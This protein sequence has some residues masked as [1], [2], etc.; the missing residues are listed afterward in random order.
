MMKAFGVSN[1]S[2]GQL[3]Q[4]TGAGAAPLDGAKGVLKFADKHPVVFEA[5]TTAASVA[6][7]PAAPAIQAGKRAIQAANTADN[8]TGKKLKGDSEDAARPMLEGDSTFEQ[9]NQ[10]WKEQDKSQSIGDKARGAI[11][12]MSGVAPSQSAAPKPKDA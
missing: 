1:D 4:L 2:Q 9:T 12:N 7:P 3:S 10:H 5:V 8:M 6:F 11:E